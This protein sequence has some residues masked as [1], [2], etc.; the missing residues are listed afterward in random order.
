MN[1]ASWPGLFC[2]ITSLG[3]DAAAPDPLSDEGMR[4]ILSE[5]AAEQI[6]HIRETGVFSDFRFGDAFDRSGISFTNVVVEDALKHFKAAHYDHGAAL[7]VADVDVDGFTD[8]YF[9][10]QIGGCQLWR[11]L[12]NGRF[13]NITQL[14]GVSLADRI[15]VAASFADTDNDGDPDL[16]VTTVRMGNVLFENMGGGRFRD[17]SKAAGVNY[18]GHSSGSAFAD[19]NHDGLLDFFVCNVGVYTSDAR[20]LGNYF[21]ALPDAFSGHTKPERAERSLLYL[22]QGGNKFREVSAAMG[23]N[24]LGWAGDAAFGDVNGDRYPDLYVLN[25]QGDDTLYINRHGNGF[26]QQTA[27]F[28]PKTP[29]GSMGIK[30][31]DFDQDGLTD[32]YVTDMHS[33]MTGLQTKLSKTTAT[34]AF[35]SVKSEQWCTAENTPEYLNNP[36]NNIFGNAFYRQTSPGKF[37]EIS[38]QIGAETFW[39]WG[40]SVGDVNAD[41]YPDV[42]VTAG[43]GYGFRYGPDSLLLNDRGQRFVAAEFVTGLEPRREGRLRKT[44]FI[45]D[46]SGADAAHPLCRGRKGKIPVSEVLSSR[47]SAFVDVDRDGDLD[48]LVN[49]MDDRPRLLLNDR[50]E[51]GNFSWLGVF[52]RGTKS[53]RDG[54]GAKVRVKAAGRNWFQEKDGKLGYLGQSSAPLYFGLG[55]TAKIE[56]IEVQW[57]SGVTQTIK[58]IAANQW[59]TVTEP[60]Q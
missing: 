11:N 9:V 1:L 8:I 7:A 56:E 51:K 14:A 59:L 47:S 20:G 28:F 40:I 2:I 41:G 46:C 26:E 39:P 50:S 45:L 29:W 13:E 32:L 21:R 52:T 16:F 18:S 43:M 55:G 24:D 58:D 22:N 60:G 35:E 34:L 54:L 15:C 31:F 12:G 27:Q 23:L 17:I 37:S 48:L 3:A 5:R 38:D 19:V 49:E 53:N 33:D 57:P 42:Y 4:Q 10:N 25:M 44:A 30:F 6:R 36:A